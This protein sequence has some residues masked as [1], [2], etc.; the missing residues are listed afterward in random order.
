MQ[1]CKRAQC[2]ARAAGQRASAASGQCMN[3]FSTVPCTLPSL[4]SSLLLSS[5]LR[6]SPFGQ[7]PHEPVT[8]HVPQQCVTLAPLPAEAGKQQ[9]GS[10][11]CGRLV[12]EER[13]W[14]AAPCTRQLSL[15]QSTS[16]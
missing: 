8:V 1:A 5:P 3:Y 9:G 13:T 11:K 15:L 14:C 7:Q 16:L 12:Q 6:V 2:M 10:G 4:L